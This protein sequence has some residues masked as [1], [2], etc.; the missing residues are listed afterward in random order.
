MATPS[1]QGELQQPDALA[2]LKT[3]IE[4]ARSTL[5]IAE[6]ATHAISEL[7]AAAR[8][9]LAEGE[10]DGHGHERSKAFAAIAAI[11]GQARQIVAVEADAAAVALPQA[12]HAPAASYAA[13]SSPSDMHSGPHGSYPQAQSPGAPEAAQS[14]V[15]L[16]CLQSTLDGFLARLQAQVQDFSHSLPGLHARLTF[17]QQLGCDAPASCQSTLDNEG[18]GLLALKTRHQ[19]TSVPLSLASHAEQSV[20]RNF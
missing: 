20:L 9:A 13:P 16:E 17:A 18:A 14:A 12:A 10:T 1:A 15:L 3:S 5:H 19:L 6:A 2:S 4:K 7:T 8:D 11:C